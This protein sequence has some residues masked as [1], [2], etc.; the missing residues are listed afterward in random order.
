[1]LFSKCVRIESGDFVSAAGLEQKGFREIEELVTWYRQPG[2]FRY[3]G[4]RKAKLKDIFSCMEIAGASFSYDRR[5]WDRGYPDWLADLSKM[6]AIGRAFF[7]PAAA[8]FVAERGARLVGFLSGVRP[9][10]YLWEPMVA[11]IDLIAVSPI[12]R[13]EGIAKSL[14]WKAMDHYARDGCS[15]IVAGTQAHNIASCQLYESLGFVIGR[16][17]RTF[18]R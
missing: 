17:Q 4:V 3:S 10:H 8:I 5:H 15:Y 9:P 11:R 1:M 2:F 14:I 13:G 6:W 16:R 12:Y 7:S 18:H